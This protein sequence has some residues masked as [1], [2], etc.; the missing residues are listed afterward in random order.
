MKKVQL[1]KIVNP[2]LAFIALAQ[3]ASAIALTLFGGM[4]PYE[5]IRKFHGLNGFLFF[6]V[7]TVHIILNWT[8]IRSNF[9]KK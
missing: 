3:F 9:F 6:A 8:W 7:I 2:I 5:T 1:L 4:I